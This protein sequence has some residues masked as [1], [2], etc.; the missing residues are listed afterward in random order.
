MCT[1]RPVGLSQSLRE[2][3]LLEVVQAQE[4]VPR[5]V[6]GAE[7]MEAEAEVGVTQEEAQVMG[8]SLSRSPL[9]VEAERERV[10]DPVVGRF[11]FSLTA[12]FRSMDQSE[13]MED[14]AAA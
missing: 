5:A 11:D 3:T 6:A 9:G 2:D 4:G 12:Q 1:S 8:P 13:P 14:S 10:P 7:G